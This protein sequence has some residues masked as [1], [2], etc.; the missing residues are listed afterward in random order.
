VLLKP[1]QPLEL[2]VT[3]EG[4]AGK[5]FVDVTFLAEAGKQ[6]SATVVLVAGK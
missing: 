1:D 4:P 3:S 6:R 2:K 5:G